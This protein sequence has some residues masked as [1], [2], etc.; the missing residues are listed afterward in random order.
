MPSIAVPTL[1][2]FGTLDG[3]IPPDRGRLYKELIPNCHLV[4]VYDAGHLA[5]VERPEAVAEVTEDFLQR[6]EAFVINRADTVIHP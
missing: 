6:H 4:F 2:L 3:M 1:V 5:N